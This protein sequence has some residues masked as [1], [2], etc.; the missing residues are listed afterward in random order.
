M[1]REQLRNVYLILLLAILVS[2]V[3]GL[4]VTPASK[5]LNFEPGRE[6][7]LTLTILNNEGRTIDAHV[8]VEGPL[9]EH[10]TLEKES[11]SFSSS[12]EKKSISYTVNLPESF[13][14][15]GI[16]SADVVVTE[17]I[18][19][20]EGE[21]ALRPNMEVIHSIFC[22]VPYP[23]SYAEARI[24]ATNS[25]E[26]SPALIT[27]PVF[28]LG[29]EPL[30]EV[31]AAITVAN[32]AGETVQEMETQ[33]KPLQSKKAGEITVEIPVDELTPGT[34]YVK[35]V[36][37]YDGKTIDLKT[38]FL[39]ERFLLKLLSI[40]ADEYN[41]GGIARIKMLIENIGNMK[42]EEVESR[43]T[44]RDAEGSLVNRIKGY[45]IDLAGDEAKE[46]SAYWDTSDIN[47]GT[48][49]GKVVLSY[50][51][52][53]REQN[54]SMDLGKEKLEINLVTG[55]V[56]STEEPTEAIPWH[57]AA[58]LLVVV[59]VLIGIRIYGKAR[60]R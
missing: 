47:L 44:V 36:L 48:Y 35:S 32:P 60:K 39:V 42:L 38:N 50:A 18:E 54:I 33:P 4:G 24:K 45:T 49:N 51:Q 19:E 2:G 52:E 46:T 1:M 34:Y 6:E 28:N 10:I 37:H 14:A 57:Y 25:R 58:I 12:D 43:I 20:E 7:K 5:N 13:G 9:K 56:I 17:T 3:H 23:E 26:G 41:E 29:E 11:V 27:I 15:P 8:H 53:S 59:A 22:H 16:K 31:W 30:N 40:M 55:K 21:I